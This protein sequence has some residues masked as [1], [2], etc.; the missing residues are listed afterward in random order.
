MIF[1]SVISKSVIT[2]QIRFVIMSLNISL[3][4]ISIVLHNVGSEIFLHNDNNGGRK[5]NLVKEIKC[6]IK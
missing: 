4:E 6:K 1:I 5:S 2:Y 3:E